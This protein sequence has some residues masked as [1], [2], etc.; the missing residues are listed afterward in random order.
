MDIAKRLIDWI[1]S[2][3]RF[4]ADC[5]GALMIEPTESNRAR[6]ATVYRGHARHCREAAASPELVSP[7]C[8]PPASG[9]WTK[10]ERLQARAAL[11]P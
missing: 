2:Y 11:E 9:A 8:T 1:P 3:D 6:N 5:A 4:P 7:P 10:S